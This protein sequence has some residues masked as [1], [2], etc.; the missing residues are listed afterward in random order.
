MM[1]VLTAVCTSDGGQHRGCQPLH[2]SWVTFTISFSVCVC[3]SVSLT[4]S[5]TT[6]ISPLCHMHNSLQHTHTHMEYQP[7]PGVWTLMFTK[8]MIVQICVVVA[9]HKICSTGPGA[10]HT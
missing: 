10:V 8:L 9:R 6:C 1:V 7:R 5:H 3:V 4:L 2:Q